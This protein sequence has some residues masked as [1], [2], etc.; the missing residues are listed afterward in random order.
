MCEI[1]DLLPELQNKIFLFL[2]HPLADAIKASYREEEERYYGS[3]PNDVKRY[4]V[5]HNNKELRLWNSTSYY[6]KV[7]YSDSDSEDSDD[8]VGYRYRDPDSEYSDEEAEPAEGYI[9]T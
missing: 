1:K 9:N 7:P 8:R 5:L 3:F 6:D 2:S 4:F